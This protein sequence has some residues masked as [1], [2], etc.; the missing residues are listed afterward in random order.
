[1]KSTQNI[2]TEPPYFNILSGRISPGGY[3][4]GMW[5][6]IRSGFKTFAAHAHSKLTRVPPPPEDIPGSPTGLAP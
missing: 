5:R 2:I 4:I 1:M 6:G 3:Y